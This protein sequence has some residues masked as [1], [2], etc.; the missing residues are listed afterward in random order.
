MRSNVAPDHKQPARNRPAEESGGDL[1]FASVW[2]KYYPK[3]SLFVKSFFR[4][5]P[6][7]EDAVQ[8]IL[9]RVYASGRRFLKAAPAAPWIYR[10]ARNYCIDCLRKRDRRGKLDLLWKNEA[11]CRRPPADPESEL[12]NREAG[13]VLRAAVEA[14]GPD[15]QQLCF[16][17][18]YEGMSVRALHRAL[19][20][21][22]GT[23]KSRLHNIKRKLKEALEASYAR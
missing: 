21:P 11:E 1:D 23:I 17:R 4:S 14:L 18:H 22:T 19:G 8:E 6:D 2:K 7:R 10:I 16:L 9:C 12:I 15:D 13:E 3:L 20:L 5:E